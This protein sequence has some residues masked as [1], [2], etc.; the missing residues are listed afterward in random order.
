MG[1]DKGKAHLHARVAYLQK[2]TSYLASQQ[3]QR[4]GPNDTERELKPSGTHRHADTEIDFATPARA[5]D[6]SKTPDPRHSVEHNAEATDADAHQA[7][8]SGLAYH[9]S[10]QTRLVALKSQI[11]LSSDFKH[12]SCKVCNAVLVDEH[13][14]K[15]AIHNASRGGQKT[16]ANVLVVECIA[17]GTEKR[18][19]VGAKRQQRKKLRATVADVKSTRST[20]PDA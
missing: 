3:I 7:P 9:I 17:C 1:K 10:S 18:Y 13:T 16:H 8:V 5:E 19:P 20:R 15:R 2:A 12:S 14:C 11:R 4:E 6:H